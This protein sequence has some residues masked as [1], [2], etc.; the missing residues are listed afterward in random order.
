MLWDIIFQLLTASSRQKGTNRQ[1]SIQQYQVPSSTVYK[2]TS[3]GAEA[4]KSGFDVPPGWLTRP[5]NGL[6]EER[7]NKKGMSA[8]IGDG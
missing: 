7:K 4:K 3:N 6:A 2:S 5:A 8:W 1:W